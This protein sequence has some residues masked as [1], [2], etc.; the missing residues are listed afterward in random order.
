MVALHNAP[1]NG[2]ESDYMG[3]LSQKKQKKNSRG[4]NALFSHGDFILA[5]PKFLILPV[6]QTQGHFKSFEIILGHSLFK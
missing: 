4:A 1:W 2:R 5:C 3:Y 6:P